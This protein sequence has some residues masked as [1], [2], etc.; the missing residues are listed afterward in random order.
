MGFTVR[1]CGP[2]VFLLL[3]VVLLTVIYVKLPLSVT[4]HSSYKMTQSRK[5]G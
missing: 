5:N 2:Y 4:T 3:S 1:C